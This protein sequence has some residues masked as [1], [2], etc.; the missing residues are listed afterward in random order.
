[1][2]YQNISKKVDPMSSNGGSQCSILNSYSPKLQ[3]CDTIAVVEEVTS[4]DNDSDKKHSCNFI[5]SS[6]DLDIV[7]CNDIP[8][9]Q[10]TNYDCA[11]VKPNTITPKVTLLNPVISDTHNCEKP[12]FELPDLSVYLCGMLENITVVSKF[13]LSK[14]SILGLVLGHFDFCVLQ[15][16]YFAWFTKNETASIFQN[17]TF[18]SLNLAALFFLPSVLFGFCIMIISKKCVKSKCLFTIFFMCCLKFC[19]YR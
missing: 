2:I 4:F 12:T 11:Y 7:I 17:L 3:K 8:E 19:K 5:E 18:L 10:M 9:K 1:M 14:I 6:M 13:L 15:V 16:T